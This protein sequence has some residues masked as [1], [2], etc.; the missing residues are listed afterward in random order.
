MLL[1]NNGEVEIF[2]SKYFGVKGLTGFFPVERISDPLKENILLIILLL[3]TGI[4]INLF[5]L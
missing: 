5:P 1:I 3:L 4:V 2:S